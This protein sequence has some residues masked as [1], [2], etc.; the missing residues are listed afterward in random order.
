MS[1]FPILSA[2]LYV[3]QIEMIQTTSSAGASGATAKMNLGA[4]L[5]DSGG[6]LSISDNEIVLPQGYEFMCIGCITENAKTGTSSVGTSITFFVNGAVASPTL[7]GIWMGGVSSG[8]GTSPTL[9]AYL[10]TVSAQST[11]SVCDNNAST[12]FNIPY[13]SGT[14]TVPNSAITILY[15]AL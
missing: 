3:A 6:L 11:L 7:V 2:G 12:G 13:N 14:A 4:I 9:I 5:H 1:F 10:K 15:K 8:F